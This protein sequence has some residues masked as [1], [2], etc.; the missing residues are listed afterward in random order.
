MCSDDCNAVALQPRSIDDALDDVTHDNIRSSEV[1][2]G[3]INASFI[4]VSY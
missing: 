1:D 3:Y 4:S 2:S